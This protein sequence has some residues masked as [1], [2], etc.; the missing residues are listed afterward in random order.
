M[1]KS[2]KIEYLF[3]DLQTCDRCIGTDRILDEV[4]ETIT[5]VLALAGYQVEYQKIEMS[6][7]EL[8]EK[9]RFQSSPTIRVNGQDICTAVK[10]S[11]C[12]CCSQISGTAVD[13]RVFEYEGSVYEVPPKAMLV[14]AIL[15]TVFAPDE[16]PC[17]N[18][19]TLPE[20]LKLFFTGKASINGSCC[21]SSG[22]C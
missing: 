20:N 16:A 6:T 15:H 5:P 11:E 7:A 4:V 13:C 8:A 3:L 22:C 12:G 19:Y 1:S 14:E 17:C 9:Y 18:G 2:V 21:C 10:E